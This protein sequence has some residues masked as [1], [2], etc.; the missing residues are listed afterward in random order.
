MICSPQVFYDISDIE[1]ESFGNG[2]ALHS[3]WMCSVVGGVVDI[4]WVHWLVG[5]VK[6]AVSPAVTPL[7]M[8]F[9]YCL[10]SLVSGVNQC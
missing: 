8:T 10:P 9:S 3:R 6:C 7:W 2:N 4:V 1:T 5:L